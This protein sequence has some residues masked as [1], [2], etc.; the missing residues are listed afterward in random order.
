MA[1]LSPFFMVFGKQN[2]LTKHGRYAKYIYRSYTSMEVGASRR[3][4][5]NFNREGDMQR[6]SF[7]LKQYAEQQLRKRKEDIMLK[8]RR[9]VGINDNGTSGYVVKQGVNK[10]KVLA[11]NN[12]RSTNNW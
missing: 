1:Y 5:P 3:N 4:A 2:M 11:H 12:T 10:D 9:E 8:A 6:H 7:M